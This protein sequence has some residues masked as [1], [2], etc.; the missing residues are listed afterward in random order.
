MFDILDGKGDQGD[1]EEQAEEVRE[2]QYEPEK[3]V[4]TE[5]QAGP[6]SKP[7]EEFDKASLQRKLTALEG[8][9]SAKQTEVLC[10]KT[11]VAE[12]SS[13]RAAIEASLAGTKHELEAARAQVTALNTECGEQKNMLE[14]GVAREE[15]QAGKLRWEETER[16]RLHNIIQEMKGNI[17]VFCR[18]RPEGDDSDEEDDD[19]PPGPVPVPFKEG[20][21][22]EGEEEREEEY[23]PEE[24]VR[25]EDQTG[26]SSKLEGD[27]SEEENDDTPPGSVPVPFKG[28][29]DEEGQ[30]EREEE[31]EP[32]EPVRTEGQAGPSSKPE[33]DDSEEEDDD[34]PPGH[35]PV[36]FMGGPGN[37][38][39][40]LT[41]PCRV[42]HNQF[43]AAKLKNM[44]RGNLGTG[45]FAGVFKDSTFVPPPYSDAPKA[46]GGP[47]GKGGRGRGRARGQSGQGPS[48]GNANLAPLGGMRGMGATRFGFGSMGMMFGR[49]GSRVGRGNSGGFHEESFESFQARCN[50]QA[51]FTIG[52]EANEAFKNQFQGMG[53]RNW[54]SGTV[55]IR[56]WGAQPPLKKTKVPPVRE[57]L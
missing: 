32:E 26:P 30:E 7:E 46:P 57:S 51:A 16:K 37:S 45:R 11:S 18:L 22:E 33:G 28:G 17:R 39:I 19:T 8:E 6:S 54:K 40:S 21:D 52:A 55:S 4:G 5:D 14:E 36:P 31:H 44:H 2:E 1:E 10:L 25:T 41:P 42:D 47:R 56:G 29:E 24:P 9:L 34:T 15:A 35:V 49:G 12:L 48:L 13:S 50:S 20:E 3:P 43:L 23:E 53:A 38:E 27:G